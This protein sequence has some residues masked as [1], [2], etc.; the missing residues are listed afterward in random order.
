MGSFEKPKQSHLIKFSQM[1]REP[2]AE[3]FN[4][5]ETGR[6][7][8]KLGLLWKHRAD[9]WGRGDTARRSHGPGAPG[10]GDMIHIMK[11]QL[12][13]LTFPSSFYGRPSFTPTVLSHPEA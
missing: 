8:V 2:L 10:S 1:V 6:G 11:G 3:I 4:E 9:R 12:S 7:G 13:F 5:N